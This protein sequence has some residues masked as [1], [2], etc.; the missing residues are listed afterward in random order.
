MA[1]PEA[2]KKSLIGFVQDDWTHVELLMEN[3]PAG[4]KAVGHF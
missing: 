1:P 2:A 4:G 3:R